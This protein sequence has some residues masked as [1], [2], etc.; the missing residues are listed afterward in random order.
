M[1]FRPV[2]RR[3]LSDDVFE[4]L[5]DQIVHGKMAPGDKLPAERALCEMLQ[6]NRGA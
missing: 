4:Q 3:S 5:L 2:T 6:V 1:P